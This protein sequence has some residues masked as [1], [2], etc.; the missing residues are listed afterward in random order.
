MRNLIIFAIAMSSLMWSC[1][2]D[3]HT[4]SD[5]TA[6]LT[7]SADSVL[8]D[9]VFTSV[10]SITR[11]IKIINQNHAAVVISSIELGGGAASAYRL[12]INGE[13]TLKRND[14]KI[15]A[16]DSVNLFV[17]V[18]IDPDSK[19]LPFIVQDSV[20]LKTNGN[21]Q[22]IQLQAYGQNAIFINQSVI[23]NNTNWTSKLPYIIKGEVTVKDHAVLNISPGAKVYFHNDAGLAVEGRLIAEGTAN[24]PVLFCSDRLETVYS[25]QAGQWKGIHLKKTGTGLIKHAIIKNASVGVTSDSLSYTNEPKL[26]LSSNIIKNMQVA[27][28]IGNHSELTAF[29]NLFYN[30]GNYLLYAVGGGEYNIKQNTFAGYNEDFPRKTAALS[31][32]DFLSSKVYNNLNLN[33][34]NNIIWGILS[35][36]IDIQRKTSANIQTNIYNNLIKTT[37]TNYANHGNKLNVEPLFVSAKNR[38]FKL[39]TGSP[40]K[41]AGINLTSDVYFGSYLDKDLQNKPRAFPSSLGCFE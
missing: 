13:S 28:Y 31:F 3:E 21:K 10:G 18:T 5:P 29:N 36:E 7:F 27:G 40:A 34:T 1:R 14:L 12:N 6:K 24:E 41:N 23:A 4:T 39:L 25:E 20:I 26:I 17:K 32:T 15:N 16:G 9:T 37:N 22:M 11:R 8:F 19:E 2:K 33:L 35:N 30:C 38:N